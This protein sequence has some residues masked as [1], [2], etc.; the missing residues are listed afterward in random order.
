VSLLESLRI[1]LTGLAA[2]RLRAVLTILAIIG[3][4]PMPAKVNYEEAQ[5]SW[6]SPLWL[7]EYPV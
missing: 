4:I 7:K 2:N 3:I 1:A 5:N 6:K